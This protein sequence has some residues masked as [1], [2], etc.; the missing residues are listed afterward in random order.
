MIDKLERLM[1]LVITL[2]ETEHLISAETIKARV[3]GYP[4]KLE[5]FRRAFERDKDELRD[6]GIPLTMDY[7][8]DSDPPLLGYRINKG[9]FY[10]PDPGLAPDE[11]TALHLAAMM[12]ELEG[13]PGDDALW[14]LGGLPNDA[15]DAVHD[16]DLTGVE[17]ELPSDP[18]LGDLFRAIQTRSQIAFSYG[19]EERSLD[20]HRLDLQNG[21]W[22]L[23]GLDHAREDVRT[24]RVDRIEGPVTAGVANAFERPAMTNSPRMSIVPWEMGEGEPVATAL[25]VDAHRAAHATTVLGDDR[26]VERR[27]DGSLVFEVSVVNWAAFRSYVLGFLEHAEILSPESS[28]DEFRAWLDSCG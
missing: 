6:L 21:W 13:T 8:S 14:T 20:P 10:L 1:D 27:V 9:D 23:T 17:I 25:L 18:R 3:P 16:H 2:L 4:D 19:S 26:I 24:F 15:N 7:I 5:S 12:V 28:R 22:Y 11:L